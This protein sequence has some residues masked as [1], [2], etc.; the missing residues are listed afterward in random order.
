MAL[1]DDLLIILCSYSRG[2]RLMRARIYGYPSGARQV[3][4][5]FE[6]ASD[7]TMR[8]TLSRLKQ[9][10][11]VKNNKTGLWKITESGRAHLSRKLYFL[12]QHSKKA[13]EN[14]L[15][16]MIISFDIPEKHK[17]KRN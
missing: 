11:F 5:R 13:T 17:H 14:H 4:P 16:N 12:P 7:A 15:K 6:K 8:V 10:G 2:Y 9:R 1:T 3:S